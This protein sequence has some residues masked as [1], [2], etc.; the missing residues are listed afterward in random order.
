MSESFGERV[1]PRDILNVL[2]T[3]HTVHRQTIE[4]YNAGAARWRETRRAQPD[5]STTAPAAR[6]FREAVGGG[7][8]LDLGCGPGA[9]LAALGDPVVGLD[10]ALA[11]LALVERI[12]DSSPLI[13][14]D[15]EALPL[16][17]RCASGAFG[18]FSFQHL[19]RPQFLHALHEVKRMLRRGGLLELWMHAS[20][21][22]DGVR[23]DDD[24]GIGRWFTYWSRDELEAAVPRAGLEVVTVE[25]HEFARRTVARRPD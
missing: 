17:D 13:A 21:G 10:A 9:A 25:D 15:I 8:I 1:V 19:P 2:P 20:P 4:S 24:I 23:D 22:V 12:A 7:L 5:T 16:R 14:G 11:M 3:I 18:S 6:A